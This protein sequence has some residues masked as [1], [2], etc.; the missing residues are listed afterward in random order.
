VNSRI[1]DPNRLRLASNSVI[2]DVDVVIAGGQ[3]DASAGTQSDV[4]AAGGV[5]EERERAMSR[6][7]SARS[8]T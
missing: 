6:V 3:T 7:G 1:A 5:P 4:A 2:A 8:V